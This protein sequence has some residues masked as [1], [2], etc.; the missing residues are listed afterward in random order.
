MN[1]TFFRMLLIV[2]L[3]SGPL[4][5]LTVTVDF[6]NTTLND[7]LKTIIEEEVTGTIGK[8]GNMPDLARGFGNANTYASQAATL[9]GYQGYDIFAVAVG[10]MLSLQAPNED[11]MFFTELQNDL[12]DGD[13][14]TGVGVTPWAVSGG[15]NLSFIIPDLYLSFKYGKFSFKTGEP[16]GY[17]SLTWKPELLDLDID[18]KRKL[19]GLSLNY[20]VFRAK[21]ILKR[22]LLWRGI[23]VESGFIYSTSAIRLKKEIDTIT[24]SSS[25]VTMPVV[26]EVVFTA[27]V[28]PSIEIE[29]N[30]KSYIIPVELYTSMRI[31]YFL[32]FG[33]GAGIDYIAGGKTDI[34]ILSAGG[35]M[36]TDDGVGGASTLQDQPGNITVDASTKD[37][38]ADK[39]RCRF[40]MNLGFTI[41]PVFIDIPLTY[42]FTDNGYA[43]GFS[44]GTV[45]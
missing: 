26:G 5:A 20:E 33:V 15:V 10:P 17:R 1:N 9:R 28:D 38:E 30:T 44:A 11:P 43:V 22:I 8:Y 19:Y 7:A 39:Y 2:V 6:G 29:L 31:L 23:S 13:V 32:N 36:I 21:S 35:I 27:D 16:V 12:D 18:Y 24:V 42:Y 34:S 3:Y 25:P 41:G 45:W 40:M 4:S 37:V 14:Y